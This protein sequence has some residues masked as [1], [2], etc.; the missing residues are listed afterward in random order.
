MADRDDATLRHFASRAKQPR[1]L[2]A[3]SRAE[4]GSPSAPPV[5]VYVIF[6]QGFGSTADQVDDTRFRYMG[7]SAPVSKYETMCGRRT[8]HDCVAEVFKW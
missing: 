2:A 5:Q 4:S 3:G 6:D 1:V 7:T 8:Q